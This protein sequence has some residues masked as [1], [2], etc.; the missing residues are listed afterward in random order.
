MTAQVYYDDVEAGDEIPVLRR[1]R[2][3]DADVLLQ[4]RHLQRPPHPL[5]QGLGHATVEGYDDVL[6]QG[7][8]QSALLSRALTDWIGGARPAGPLSVQNRA[9]A[10]PGEELDLRG[11]G[12]RQTRG[13]RSRPGRPRHLG[14]ARRRR[15]DAGHRDRRPAATRPDAVRAAGLRGD[16]AIVGIAE[17]P[18]QRKQ[19][20]PELFT[21]DQYARAGGDGRR[22][23]RVGCVG[24]QRTRLPRG[25]G[26]R[27]VRP[28]HP[29]RIPR[30]ACRF[31]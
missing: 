18:A 25:R 3:R 28:G 21:I 15:P 4:R 30:S 16:A 17:L 6:V 2:R 31:R 10:Y 5:R 27:D 11:S 24:D 8:L 19:T 23:R 22:R 29:Q 14:V 12:H 26:V 20:R 9:V 1:H 7:P 13:R